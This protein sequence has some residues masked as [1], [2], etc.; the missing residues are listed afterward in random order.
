M[1]YIMISL[2][3]M[4]VYSYFGVILNLNPKQISLAIVLGVCIGFIFWILDNV[5]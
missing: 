1:K 4:F 5:K 2:I 3:V